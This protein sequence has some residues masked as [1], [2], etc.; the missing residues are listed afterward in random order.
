MN[1]DWF[2][3]HTAL[4][5]VLAIAVPTMMYS[6][7]R[8]SLMD[9]ADHA[10]VCAS[11]GTIYTWRS[12]PWRNWWMEYLALILLLGN[13]IYAD[14]VPLGAA[15]WAGAIAGYLLLFSGVRSRG[16]RPTCT[17]CGSTHWLPP[18]SPRGRELAALSHDTT[19][20]Q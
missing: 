8:R 18:E 14:L 13:A 11:C 19:Q 9:A 6:A 10:L 15:S 2:L 7:T 17:A 4:T 20:S 5:A 3:H 12:Q 1:F 16:G